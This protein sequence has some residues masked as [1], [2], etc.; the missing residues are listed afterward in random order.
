MEYSE[1]RQ[2][3][4]QFNDDE[5][6]VLVKD[7]SFKRIGLALRKARRQ[8]ELSIKD[9]SQHL[10]IS[11][12]YLQK[13]EAGLFDDLPAPVYV[14]GFLRSYG[15]FLR[16]EPGSLPRRYEALI[17]NKNKKPSHKMPLGTRPP[18]RSAPVIAS[19][20]VILSGVTY[21][22]WFWFKGTTEVASSATTIANEIPKTNQKNEI[23]IENA[24]INGVRLGL[25]DKTITSDAANQGL[26]DT[27]NEKWILPE[28]AALSQS[29]S[30]ITSDVKDE[31]KKGLLNAGNLKT[32]LQNRSLEKV[33]TNK[34]EPLS[35]F[36]ENQI[37][38]KPLDDNSPL[39]NS[40]TAVA[41]LRDPAQEITIHA[42]AASWVEIV[43]DNGEEV[44]AK[45]MQAGDVYV[46]DGNLNLYLSTGNAGGLMVIIG[47]SD[48]LP[49]GG[50]G[51][52]VRDLPL[53]KGK[54]RKIL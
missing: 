10:R 47:S 43:R 12:D 36:T 35:E 1:G 46:V 32:I 29:G 30:E 4:T 49:I 42:V 14:S 8:E 5:N 39:Q 51:E 48:P 7:D 50:V 6:K 16:L 31:V 15:Q 9:V 18:Q 45:L 38:A 27:V 17:L 25:G 37:L 13:L 28:T 11:V 20:L 33:E 40:N 22:S 41:N 21:A 23:T 24:S 44:M 52:I 53:S 2:S 19:M 3:L 26:T 34:S 54:L